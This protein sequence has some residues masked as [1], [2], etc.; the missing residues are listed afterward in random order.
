MSVS[1]LRSRSL[2]RSARPMLPA[3]GQGVRHP[4]ANADLS[5][6]ASSLDDE[7]TGPRSAEG[8]ADCYTSW[9]ASARRNHLDGFAAAVADSGSSSSRRFVAQVR[10]G[11][12]SSP[13]QPQTL[14]GTPC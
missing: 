7:L 6:A 3:K 10:L 4:K 1:R 8:P 9:H 5:V 2:P 13:Q 14:A 12:R 11:I